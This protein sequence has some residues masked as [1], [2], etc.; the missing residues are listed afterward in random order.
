MLLRI[1]KNQLSLDIMLIGELVKFKTL[2]ITSVQISS[3][4]NIDGQF[5]NE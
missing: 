5:E 3:W 1:K 2:L 4:S